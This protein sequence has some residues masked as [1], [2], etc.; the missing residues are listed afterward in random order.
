MERSELT[1]SATRRAG[2][3]SLADA[4][5]RGPG[6]YNPQV[7]SALAL[8]IFREVLIV[9]IVVGIIGI[10]AA[11]HVTHHDLEIIPLPITISNLS[12]A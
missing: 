4:G 6:A 8:H 2:R 12:I 11:I 1:D 3:R 10:V 7:A 9:T 5:G